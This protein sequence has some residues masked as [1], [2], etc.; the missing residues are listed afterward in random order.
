MSIPSYEPARLQP[1]YNYFVQEEFSSF[2]KRYGP[3][4]RRVLFIGGL[5]FD[6]RCIPALRKTVGLFTEAD[7]LV[8]MCAR[9]TNLHDPHLQ[10]N[11]RG[12]AA[13]LNVIREIARKNRAQDRYHF[14]V[15]VNLFDAAGSQIG[16]ALLI[17]EFD[18]C[19]GASY[20]T[21]TDVIVDVSAFPRSMMYTLLGHLWRL[22]HPQ[23]NLFVVYTQTHSSFPVEEGEYVDASYVRGE[24][25]VKKSGEQVWIPILGGGMERLA[26]VYKF[27]KPEDVFPIIPFPEADARRGDELLTQAR[28]M[29]FE[30][31]GVPFE[32][33]M[34]ASG[35]TPWDVFRKIVDFA[36]VHRVTKPAANLVVSALSGSRA[37]SVGALTAS[38]WRDLY[39]CHSQPT[40]Y[41]MSDAD[42][43]SASKECKS[44][45][46]TLFWLA[47]ELY[48][49][50]PNGVRS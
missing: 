25:H 23:Q 12:T 24:R 21:F 1:I 15:E 48:E 37:L 10:H 26:A 31:W 17:R 35:S 27:L 16:D 14:E 19:V 32:N 39:M 38:L 50:R 43:Q 30:D 40:R 18:S 44:A 6:P 33:I 13:S 9:F 3:D 41:Y 11:L 29:I 36:E 7:Q 42:R 47:G 28:K 5:G 49:G 22:R 2:W 8:T 4:G 34:Y 46:S 20:N 45:K